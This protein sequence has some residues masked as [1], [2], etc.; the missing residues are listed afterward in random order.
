MSHWNPE[1]VSESVAGALGSSPACSS[2][3]VASTG[4]SCEP[5]CAVDDAPAIRESLMRLSRKDGFVDHATTTP[6]SL[7]AAIIE[8][9]AFSIVLAEFAGTACCL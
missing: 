6:I 2:W 8:P 7:Y 3:L 5:R 1:K 9:P 4:S